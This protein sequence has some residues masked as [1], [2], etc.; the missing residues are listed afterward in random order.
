MLL[1]EGSAGLLYCVS[2]CGDQ[3]ADIA[4]IWRAAVTQYECR[5]TMVSSVKL[6]WSMRVGGRKGLWEVLLPQPLQGKLL[7]F[8]AIMLWGTVWEGIE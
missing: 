8:D 6:L 5:L 4:D 1:Q 2:N 7:C 3:G